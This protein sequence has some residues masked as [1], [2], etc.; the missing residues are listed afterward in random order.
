MDGKNVFREREQALEEGY[1]RKQDAKLLEKL[2]AR[3]TFGELADA[4]RAKL[5]VDDPALLARLRDLGL[6]AET[7][8]A[9]LLAPLVQVAW[10]DGKV[11]PAERKAVMRIAVD[12]GLKPGSPAHQQLEQWLDQ[13]PPADLYETAIATIRAG[14]SVLPLDERDERVRRYVDA[15]K[16]VAMAAG[17]FLE[18]FGMG[19]EI[20]GDESEVLDAIA[21][22]LHK[23]LKPDA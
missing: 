9:V 13:R 12:R 8:P 23:R 15:C 16:H 18:I 6:T 17:G 22:R 10:A 4:L 1:F 20:S 7:G 11:A 2:R 5:D 3:A 14:L 21:Q 19:G